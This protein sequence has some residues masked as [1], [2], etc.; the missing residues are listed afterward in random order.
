LIEN[1]NSIHEI[2][3]KIESYLQQDN[4]SEI[5][6]NNLVG[7]IADIFVMSAASTFGYRK[8]KLSVFDIRRISSSHFLCYC[9]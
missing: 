7:D 5:E 1:E 2:E 6:I 8:Y 3:L 4:I 9:E